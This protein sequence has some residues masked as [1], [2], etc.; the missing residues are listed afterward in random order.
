M[1]LDCP[2][3]TFYCLRSVVHGNPCNAFHLFTDKH[4]LRCIQ[5]HTI[6]YRKKDNDDFN[7]HLYERES[8][9]GLQVARGVLVGKDTLVKQ[10]WSK[11]WVN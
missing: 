10:L 7:L 9:V 1:F 4:M 2:G 5:K 11:E 3:S 6:N 8:F